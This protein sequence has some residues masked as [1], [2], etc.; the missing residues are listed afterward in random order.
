MTDLD[1]VR[2]KVSLGHTANALT[3]SVAEVRSSNL[4]LDKGESYKNGYLYICIFIKTNSSLKRQD[5]YVSFSTDVRAKNHHICAV[6]WTAEGALVG[7]KIIQ[8]IIN[9]SGV[10]RRGCSFFFVLTLCLPLPRTPINR[11]PRGL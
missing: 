9:P 10:P 1:A 7:K 6:G 5:D 3:D 11:L 4:L 2:G 8:P